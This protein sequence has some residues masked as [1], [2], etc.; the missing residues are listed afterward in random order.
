MTG[1]IR[2][3]YQ[4][5]RDGDS[6]HASRAVPRSISRATSGAPRSNPATNGKMLARPTDARSILVT[7]SPSFAIPRQRGSM[8][9]KLS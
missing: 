6:D 5:S 8:L 4:R 7:H 1:A 9:P 3:T 2:W